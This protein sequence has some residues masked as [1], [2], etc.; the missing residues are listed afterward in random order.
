MAKFPLEIYEQNT[1]I[2]NDDFDNIIGDS[3]LWIEQERRMFGKD[4]LPFYS[5]SIF[6][7]IKKRSLLINEVEA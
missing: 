5:W 4:N 2:V 3:G 6:D 7:K 1:I